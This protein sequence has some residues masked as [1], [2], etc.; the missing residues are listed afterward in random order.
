MLYTFKLKCYSV[1]KL[2]T[3]VHY[4]YTGI[5]YEAICKAGRASAYSTQSNFVY[6]LHLCFGCVSAFG[7][8]VAHCASCENVSEV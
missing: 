2:H 6:R 8:A 5:K 7:Q 1:N 3:I 4:V